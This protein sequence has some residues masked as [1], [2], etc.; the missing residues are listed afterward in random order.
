[1]KKTEQILGLDIGVSSIGLAII[2]VIN[3]IKSIE[4][5]SVRIVP[6]DPNFH[7]KFYTGNTA[8]KNLDR[9]LKRGIRRNN[10]RFKARRDELYAALKANNMFPSEANFDLEVKE[11]YGLRASAAEKKISRQELGRV[12]VL[13]NQRRGFLSNRKSISAEE[14]SSEYKER[15]ALLEKE[16]EGRTIGQQLFKELSEA[17]NTFDILLRERIYQRSSYIE[18]FDRIWLTQK[19]YHKTLTGGPNEHNNKATLY[20]KLRNKIIYYQRPLKSQKGSVSNCLFE[21]HHKSVTKSSPY[22]EI[23]RIWQKIN[24]LKVTMNNGDD[25][26][27]TQEQKEKLYH[28]LFYGE[29]LNKKN[30]LTVTAIKKLLGLKRNEGYLNFT[31][32][33]GSNT[34]NKLK[35]ALAKAGIKNPEKHLAFDP[36]KQNEAKGL[37]EL[38][39]IT[40][41][42]PN[43]KDVK[44]TLVKRFGFT[45]KQSALI[46]EQVGYKSDYGNLSTRAIK[47]LL[48]SLQ[49][50]LGYSEAC[51]AI[52]YDHSGY[53]T[54]IKLKKQLEPIPKNSLRNPVVEQ[55][56]NQ[57]VNMVNLAVAEYGAFDE[58]RIE[59]ARELRNSAKTRER[60]TKSNSANKRRSDWIRNEL[61]DNYGFKIVNGRDVKRYKLWEETNK[62]CL[63]CNKPINKTDLL[64]GSA[65]IEHILPRSR[66]FSNAMSNYILAHRKCN[67]TKGQR[68]AYDYL[69]SLGTDRLSGYIE[70]VNKLYQD[71]KGTISKGKFDNLLCKGENIPTDFVDRMKKDSQYIAKVA[72]KMLKSICTNTYTTTGQI[73]D[74]LRHE[75]KLKSVLQEL[76]FDKYKA[77]GQTTTKKIKDAQ[78]KEKTIEIITNW[79][80]RDD[81]RH[82]A[83]DALICALTDQKII[84]KLNNLNK[85]YQYHKNELSTAELEELEKNLGGKFSFKEFSEHQGNI[86]DC[87]IKNIREVTK[88]HLEE[89][90]ISF[91]KDNSKVLTHNENVIK[92]GDPQSTWVPRG[93]LHEETVMGQIRRISEK[94]IKLN[95]KFPLEAIPNIVSPIVKKLITKRLVEYDNKVK[96]AFDTKQLKK[97]PIKYKGD[98]LQEVKIWEDVSTKRVEIESF[99]ADG[100]KSK[101]AKIKLIENAS[102]L[103]K[104]IGNA[105]SERLK[106]NNND[107][108]RAFSELDNHPVK[109]KNGKTIKSITVYAESK[110]IAV[111][112]KRDNRGKAILN[113]NSHPI[114]ANF[115]K[116]GGNHH[117]L[118]YIDRKGEY[119]NEVVTFWDA[120]AIGLLN[121][122]QT[123]K[124]YP[125]INRKEHS[126]FGRLKFSMQINDLF[127][128]DL[129]HARNPQEENEIDF[130]ENKNRKQISQQLYRVQKM[131]KKKTGAFEVT[132]R[133]HLE[134]TIDRSS[135]NLKGITWQ[136][137]GSKNHF[138]RLTKVR[139]NHLG[140]IVKVGE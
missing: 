19:K 14:N 94:P 45:Q 3:G 66:S 138:A 54:E 16:L 131:S 28:S 31:E 81:H 89:L 57:L 24:D 127:V 79:T 39:H 21:K 25:I 92:N 10:Q 12:L 4:K 69:E 102:K 42:I 140:E 118:I 51:D 130:L 134:A 123:G 116:T 129:K 52:G 36:Y 1:M 104:A 132:Y 97:N 41:S 58:I 109:L 23:F 27:P 115:V 120:V 64:S 112:R 124:P 126:E 93:R 88:K 56:L 74:L 32:I 47:K 72:V 85:L 122:E 67:S 136:E 87:P 29:N 78:G 95:T 71:G 101:S 100:Q 22:F 5:L 35:N 37:L 125:I 121:I 59:L 90:F 99:F 34:Y 133:H 128:F 84:F 119:H 135:S 68:T 33:L 117:A 82:H 8:S 15:I 139:L 62:Q 44:N 108:K 43:E 110:A 103:D 9:T 83:V 38:W 46:A 113:E 86:Y 80:K 70:H 53:K 73:T 60:I 111:G 75:W 105:L 11:L 7:G 2:K 55:I 30:E 106:M 76:S 107:F 17:E 26:F 50:G 65:E 13:L 6:E 40:Y 18:E 114:P 63:Y 91:K 137:H 98:A 61:K 77:I 96:L 20:N 49:K 48:P